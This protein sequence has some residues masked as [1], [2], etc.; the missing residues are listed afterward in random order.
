MRSTN[1]YP[2]AILLPA[3][4]VILASLA[5]LSSTP[6]VSTSSTP[7]SIPTPSPTPGISQLGEPWE[8]DG[9]SVSV[10]DAELG[11]CFTSDYGSEICPPEGAQYLWVHLERENLRDQADLP[12]YSCFW[13]R[14]HYLGVELHPRSYYEASGRPDWSGGGCGGLYAGYNDDG[15][16]RFEV[17]LGIDLVQ[18]L[19]RI[20][21]Y[22]GPQFERIWILVITD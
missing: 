2:A 12:I 15:W 13:I 11:T 8:A 5:C 18:A 7:W 10:S 17:P 14:L 4:S 9:L 20:E 22:Q 3:L 6:Q 21:S 1:H 16:V 19:L